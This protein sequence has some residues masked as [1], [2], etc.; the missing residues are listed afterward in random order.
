MGV[1]PNRT[2]AWTEDLSAITFG[3]RKPKKSDAK[4]RSRRQGG[5]EGRPAEA[6]A[7]RE[8]GA[9]AGGRAPSTTPDEEK[10]DLVIWHYKD[11]RLQSQQQVQEETDK[12]FSY[13]CI[14]HV[15]DKKFVRLADDNVRSVSLAPKEKFAIGTDIREYELMANL[16]GRNYQDVYVIDPKTGER[17]LA[18]KK[19]R[20]MRGPSTDG[21]KFLYYEDGH[22]FVY[23]MATGQSVNITKTVPTSFI[24]TEDDHNV[25]KPPHA[26]ARLD[27][28]RR[29]G[30]AVGRLG[31]LEG[32]GD[33]RDRHEPHRERQE[34]RHPLP[35]RAAA[36][37]GGEGL[38]PLG[39]PL[40]PDVRRV[41]EEGRH[42]PPRSGQAGHHAAALGRR[43]V[44][45]AEGEEGRRV[46]LHEVDAVGPGRL[47]RD[48]RL[49]EGRA[50]RSRRSTR[51]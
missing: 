50:R 43:G 21:T 42:R 31:H 3:I 39:R 7:G 1:S 24:D 41:H 37:P 44:R 28:G 11:P 27:E 2:P 26:V 30:A 49:A 35:Q 6:G 34:G 12:N 40:H 16:D 5:R 25:V 15:A 23:D 18:L 10:P 51:R 14:Y 45:G 33:R 38:G 47:L 36:R 4:P 29:R 46:P 9:E 19:A 22:Y 13:L 32:A 17:K 8:T 48:R 20:W